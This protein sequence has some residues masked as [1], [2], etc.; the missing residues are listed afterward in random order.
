MTR[1]RSLFSL[2]AVAVLAAAS[3][4]EAVTSTVRAGFGYVRDF[5]VAAFAEVPKAVQAVVPSQLSPR[6]AL[7]AAKAFAHRLM[8]RR[9]TV[10]PTS[11]RMCSST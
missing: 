7:V 8:R 4:F 2:L 11:W 10:Q 1:S 6:V 3:A 5:V 9:P